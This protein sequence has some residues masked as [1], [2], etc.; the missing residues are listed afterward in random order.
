MEEIRGVGVRRAPQNHLMEFFT[1]DEHGLIRRRVVIKSGIATDSELRAAKRAGD[2]QSIVRGVAAPPDD[3]DAQLSRE[4]QY[5]RIVISVAGRSRLRVISHQSAAIIH[6]IELLAPDHRR[7]HVTV[8]TKG[9]VE[10]VVHVHQAALEDADVVVIDGVR[11]TTQA[12]TACD[13]ARSGSFEQAVAALDSALRIGVSLAEL[14]AVTA[15]YPH[16][17]GIGTLRNALLVA[18]GDAES[19]GE[20]LSRALMVGWDDIPAPTLQPKFYDADGFIGRTDFG[21][22]GKVVGEFDGKTKY[23]R[24]W[25]PGDRPE[26]VVYREKLRED[27]LRALGL[28]VVRWTWDDLM[29]PARLRAKIRKALRDAEIV[30]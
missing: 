3:D 5:R 25:R 24:S 27:R 30:G 22:F 12:L 14:H 8:R 15:R 29:E 23:M 21:W 19:V 2:L 9:K 28:V 17:E 7:V 4:Q 10:G 18:D 13:V 16:A 26:E 6:G 11:V 20:S 1:P